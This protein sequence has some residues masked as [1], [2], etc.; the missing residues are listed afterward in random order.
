[1][2]HAISPMP[3][4]ISEFLPGRDVTL[5]ARVWRRPG[6]GPALVVLHGSWES[7]RTFA[8][9]AASAAADRTVYCLD[10][11]GHGRS[12]RPAAGYRFADY[13][14]DVL[15]LLDHLAERHGAIDVLGHSLG[16]NVALYTAAAGHPALGRVVAVDPPVLLPADWPAVRRAMARGRRLA[17]RPVAEIER[18][19]AARSVRDPGWLRMMAGALAATADGV[20]AAIADGEQGEVD[21]ARTLA[22]IGV[23][24]LALAPDPAVPGGQLTGARLAAFRRALPHAE[25]VAV[26]GAGHHIEADRPAEFERAVTAFLDRGRS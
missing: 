16:A 4:A 17:R 7:W 9:F 21:W 6:D 3:H 23:P 10:L 25:I 12:D 8:P 15:A 11:R 14:A 13:A 20:F 19:M 2:T 5:H 24:V 22:P 1:M 18:T 26:P